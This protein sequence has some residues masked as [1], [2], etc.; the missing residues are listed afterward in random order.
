MAQDPRLDASLYGNAGPPQPTGANLA[1]DGSNLAAS[2]A[3]VPTAQNAQAPAAGPPNLI[4][5]AMNLFRQGIISQTQLDKLMAQF[6]PP[7][8]GTQP[9]PTTPLP[10][11]GPVPGNIP[12][13]IRG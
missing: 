7:P 8:A 13:G 6:A 11:P 9:V 4:A 2:P 12:L 1:A 5:Q 10:T 3:P